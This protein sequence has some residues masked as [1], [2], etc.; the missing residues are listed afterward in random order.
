MKITRSVFGILA[1]AALLCGPAAQANS[2][3]YTYHGGGDM[4]AESQF[5]GTL[6]IAQFDPSLGV[7]NSIDLV[8]GSAYGGQVAISGPDGAN[9]SFFVNETTT[10][11]DAG[12]NLD[13]SI[14]NN[15]QGNFSLPNYYTHIGSSSPG[16]ISQTYDS[17]SIL[18]EFTG[19]G[20][21]DLQITASQGIGSL[22]PPGVTAGITDGNFGADLWLTYNY[23]PEN[24]GN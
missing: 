20:I 15:W 17:P 4:G 13:A 16:T 12:N 8:F 7:L 14:G 11:K 10:F 24:T 19:L 9:G 18:S 21:F 22:L 2:I 1:T 3:D 23:T 5:N 6:S